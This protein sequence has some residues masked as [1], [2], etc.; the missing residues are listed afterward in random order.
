MPCVEKSGTSGCPRFR[1]RTGEGC[2]ISACIYPSFS[3]S[4]NRMTFGIAGPRCLKNVVSK[5]PFSDLDPSL[6]ALQWG[7]QAP[8]FSC[9]VCGPPAAPSPLVRT[10]RPDGQRCLRSLFLDGLVACQEVCPSLG[11]M[12]ASLG[13]YGPVTRQT[14]Y[15]GDSVSA[16]EGI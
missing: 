4:F 13:L 5:L 1:K 9:R 10:S 7:C 2:F 3:V 14:L 11:S 12:T 16:L 15:F 6:A 8:G